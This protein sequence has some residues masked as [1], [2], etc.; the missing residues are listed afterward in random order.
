MIVK[1]KKTALICLLSD[2]EAALDKLQELGIMHTEMTQLVESRE[3]PALE[4]LT[5]KV[6]NIIGMLQS[7]GDGK[8][9]AEC[10]LSGKEVY[11]KASE[12]AAKR[13][14]IEKQL[15]KLQRDQDSLNP[16]GDF[17]RKLLTDLRSKGV[18]VYL[19]SGTKEDIG[20]LPEGTVYEVIRAGKN[21]IY[22]AVISETELDEGA[23]PLAVLPD[24]ISLKQAE[25]EIEKCRKN[26]E[27]IRKELI[28]LET[29]LP[30]LREYKEEIDEELDFFRVRD[31]MGGEGVFA[32][33]KGFVPVPEIDKLTASAKEHGWALLIQDPTH[34]DPP[35]T[36][37]KT[38]KIF[39]IA[40]PIFNFI[41]IAPGY[42][43]NDVSVV[44]LIFFTIFFGMIVGD[45]A[46]GVIFLILS[47]ICKWVFRKNKAARLPIN[48]FIV[49]SVTTIVWGALTGTFFGLPQNTIPDF[50]QGFNKLSNPDIKDKNIQFLCFLIAAIHLSFARTWKGILQWNWR[51]PGQLGWA[52]IIWGNFLLATK[53][54]VFPEWTIPTPVFLWIYGVALFLILVF[55]V[56]WKNVGMVLNFPFSLMGSFVDVLSYIRLFAVGLSSFYIA[57]SFNKMGSMVIKGQSGLALAGLIIVM[58]LIVLIGHFLN[59]LLALMGVLVHGIRLNTLEF[60]NHMELEWAGVTYKPFKKRDQNSPDNENT[61][62]KSIE[63]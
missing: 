42:Y 47:L 25:D 63:K 17:S 26:L 21:R 56:D 19:C 5:G 4:Q 28:G 44:F 49:L 36:L 41:G 7:L 6:D 37:I 29:G 33:I 9:K 38:P 23:L 62:K 54:I 13:A 8:K 52:I 12:L 35:P 24:D 51:S 20:K 11:E 3:R 1:M 50:M 58:V 45:A 2:K 53:L 15:D 18:N 57:N 40:K 30:Q 32:Y 14:E 39:N 61:D 10:K 46:Y 43:E 31:G 59:I 60:S 22:F 16:W 27:D 48:L 55:Y 34:D